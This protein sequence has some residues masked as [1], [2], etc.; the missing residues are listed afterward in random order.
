MVNQT[1]SSTQIKNLKHFGYGIKGFILSMIETYIELTNG[2][3]K[4][5]EI[6]KIIDFSRDMLAAQ[7][8]LLH[9]VNEVIDTL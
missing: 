7:V 6:Q 2:E 5:N 4:R 9:Y 3:T 1:L 8:E